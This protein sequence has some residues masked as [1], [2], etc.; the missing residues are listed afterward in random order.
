M[1]IVNTIHFGNLV[2]YPEWIAVLARWH[3]DEWQR[4]YQ[5][6]TVTAAEEELACHLD[7]SRIPTT[8]V[9]IEGAEPIGSVSL[10]E[11][12]L[13]G[14]DHLSPWLASLFVRPDRRRQG[15]GKLLVSQAVAKA[16]E[17][18]CEMLYLFTTGQ[19]EFYA[20]LGWQVVASATAAD[21][22]VCVMAKRL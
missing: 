9:A 3:V 13:P 21:E 16:Q 6:W 1:M 4:L 20:A 2:D 14:W 17:I 7:P 11:K 22:P 8:V 12:D 19:Q 18:G 5:G 10:V 15:I